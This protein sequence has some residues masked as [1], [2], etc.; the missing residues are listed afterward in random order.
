MT[1]GPAPMM[2]IDSR[3]V[4]LG[5]AQIAR[6]VESGLSWRKR[7]RCRQERPGAS[8]D[9]RW[10]AGRLKVARASRPWSGTIP[11]HGQDAHA[12]SD[13]RQSADAPGAPDLALRSAGSPPDLGLLGLP[14]KNS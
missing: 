4:R 14:K 1:M 9:C 6:R 10:N 2:R 12:T 13:N 3:S 8:A 11:R 7:E 5:M